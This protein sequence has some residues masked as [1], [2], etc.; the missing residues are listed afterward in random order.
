M[1]TVLELGIADLAGTRFAV[2]PLHETVRAVRLL[3]ERDQPAVNRPWAEWARARLSETPLRLPRVWPLINTGLRSFPEFLGPAPAGQSPTLDDEL[4]RVRATPEAAVRASLRR[5]FGTGEWPDSATELDADPARSLREI[6]AEYAAC[7]E[8]LIAPHWE[9]LK[10]VLDADIAYRTGVLARGGARALFGDMHPDL[11]WADGVLRLDDE[12][13]DERRVWLGP[14]G[15]VLL[16]SVFNWPVVSVSMATSS[17]TVL[18]YPARGAATVWH[19]VSDPPP[20]LPDLLGVTRARM[21]D[22]LRSPAT[23]SALARES[24]VTPGAVSQ[25]L[26]VLYRAGL[27]TRERSGR[28]VL[29]QTSDLGLALLAIRT[30]SIR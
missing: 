20:V 6:A 28:S 12:Y 30:R 25:H 22:V 19:T 14:D 24:G 10:A 5:V 2:S 1:A 15:V 9:R 16:P 21:L 11:H 8:R 29:Y 26:A 7:Y 4:A 23:T 13:Q 18:S 27:L 17:Q 3:G